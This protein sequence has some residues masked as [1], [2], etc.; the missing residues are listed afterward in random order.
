MIF[1]RTVC[2]IL[3]LSVR[4]WKKSRKPCFLPYINPWLIFCLFRVGLQVMPLP[5]LPWC[6]LQMDMEVLVSFICETIPGL[7]KSSFLLSFTSLCPTSIALHWKA[8]VLG[9][10]LASWCWHEVSAGSWHVHLLPVSCHPPGHLSVSCCP[11]CGWQLWLL[12][13][14][15]VHTALSWCCAAL[16]VCYCLNLSAVQ[17]WNKS[18]VGLV[19]ICTRSVLTW[20]GR[21]RWVSDPTLLW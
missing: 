21:D 17:G 18:S 8:M 5:D 12:R 19:G 7:A 20:D 16:A 1:E 13:V 9:S 6:V 3:G 14:S 11:P 15:N 10:V 2:A 4:L